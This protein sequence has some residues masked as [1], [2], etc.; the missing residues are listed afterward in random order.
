[1]SRGKGR[2]SKDCSHAGRDVNSTASLKAFAAKEVMWSE[3]RCLIP[4]SQHAVYL[5]GVMSFSVR[6]NSQ[7]AK[8]VLFPAG[9]GSGSDS[10]YGGKFNDEKPGLKLKHEA[11]VVSM[12]NSGKNTNR[13]LQPYSQ[14]HISIKLVMTSLSHVVAQYPHVFAQLSVLPHPGPCTPVRWQACC[15]WQNCGGPGHS[16]EDR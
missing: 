6:K 8:I 16:E 10:I 11:G 2:A 4:P 3:V 15:L 13:C 7:I 12:A 1:M 5:T 14:Y 9:D